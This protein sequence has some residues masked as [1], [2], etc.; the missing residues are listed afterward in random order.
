MLGTIQRLSTMTGPSA[1]PAGRNTRRRDCG[2]V[3]RVP[4][5]G[6][7][8]GAGALCWVPFG[9]HAFRHAGRRRPICA[10]W[11]VHHFG[12]DRVVKLWLCDRVRDFRSNEK[13]DGVRFRLVLRL[14]PK[15]DVG[16]RQAA[17]LPSIERTN[18]RTRLKTAPSRSRWTRPRSLSRNTCDTTS[19]WSV[20]FSPG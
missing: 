13:I 10:T 1:G 14:E 7:C 17:L 4:R 12:G 18:A 16:V 6:H 15:H 2:P 19:G 11:A 20:D 3:F 9:A 8:S 5:F